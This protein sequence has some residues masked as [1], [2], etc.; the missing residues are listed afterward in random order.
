[1]M[2]KYSFIEHSQP[3]DATIIQYSIDEIE[4]DIQKYIDWISEYKK[5]QNN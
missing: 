5:R 4:S 3:A 2:S 1:M